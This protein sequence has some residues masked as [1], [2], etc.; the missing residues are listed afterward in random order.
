MKKFIIAPLLT[1]LSLSSTPCHSHNVNALIASTINKLQ[2]TSLP[3][4][5]RTFIGLKTQ[6]LGMLPQGSSEYQLWSSLNPECI[7]DINT[8]KTLWATLDPSTQAVIIKKFPLA[9]MLR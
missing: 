1:I 8:L 3:A 2:D 9:S 4:L 6:V 5:K 7:N